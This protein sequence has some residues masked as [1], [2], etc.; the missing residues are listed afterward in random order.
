MK[1]ILSVIIIGLLCFSTFTIF[2]PRAKAIADPSLVGYWKFDE[3]S[4]NT[5]HDSSGNGNDG[6]INQSEWVQGIEGYALRF[7]SGNTYVLTKRFPDGIGDNSEFTISFWVKIDKWPSAQYAYMVMFGQG[8]DDVVDVAF[9]VLLD[10]D[11]GLAPNGTVRPSFWNRHV[12]TT[13]TFATGVWYDWAFVYD[14]TE[15]KMYQNGTFLEDISLGGASPN[16]N[17]SGPVMFSAPATQFFQGILDEVAIYN[18]AR[19]PEEI[20]NDYVKAS[21]AIVVPDDYARIQWAIGNASAGDTIYVKAGTYYEHVVVDKAVS[22]IG[23]DRSSTI[24]DG[25][26]TGN[27]INITANNVNLTGFTIQKSGPSWPSAGIYIEGING[28]NISN[29]IITNNDYGIYLLESSNNT[30]HGNSITAN[31]YDGVWLNGSSNNAIS[32]NNVTKNGAGI[33]LENSSN[34]TISG[35]TIRGN[36]TISASNEYGIGLLDSSSNNTI[37]ENN[38]TANGDFGIWLNAS[39][40]NRIFENDVVENDP[41]DGISLQF[42]SNYNLIYR[43][44]ITSNTGDGISTSYTD[45]SIIFGNVITGNARGIELFYSSHNNTISGNNITEN[46]V[47]GIAVGYSSRN[48]TIYHNNLIDN[49]HQAIIEGESE[50]NVWDDG[51]PSGGNY[52]SDYAGVDRYSGPNQNELGSDGIGDT[53][54]AIDGNNADNYPL[55][56]PWGT[57]PNYDWPM[58]H[59]DLSH[60][61]YSASTAPNTNHIIWNYTTGG[62]IW[63]SPAIAGGKVYVGS[64]DYNVYCLN[65]TTGTKIWNY[66]TGDAIT[67]SPAVV[68]GKV[69]I[70]SHDKKFYALNASNGNLI[71]NVTL[72]SLVDWSSPAVVDGKI[73]I[74]SVFGGVY[75]LNATDG[76]IIWNNG[77]SWYT[78]SPA[79]YDGKVYIGGWDG[80]LYAH[81]ATDGAILWS[82]QTSPK[83]LAHSSPAVA[84][85]GIV[86][87]G[88]GLFDDDGKQVYALNATNGTQ[89]W[90][91]TTGDNVVSSPAVVDGVVYIGSNDMN[92]Y[93]LNASTGVKLWSYATGGWVYSSPAVADGKVYL[94]S[95]N[96]NVYCFRTPQNY[97]LTIT[98]TEA[99][100]TWTVPL[101]INVTIKYVGDFTESFNVTLCWNNTNVIGTKTVTLATG[102]TKT[103]TYTWNIPTIPK[104]WPYPIYT[105]KAYANLTGDNELISSTVTVKWPGDVDGNGKVRLPDLTTLAKAWYGD[106]GGT[107]AERA[108]Y[109]YKCDFDMNGEV[110]LPDLVFLAKNWYKGPLD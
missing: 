107:A 14:K 40:N 103:L 86:Y 25:N 74:A 58:F 2:T 80:K 9:H 87:F 31:N 29:N 55:V 105:F 67:A 35:N 98:A 97:T 36:K 64:N 93:A 11:D 50:T 96:H 43:N 16:F 62:E 4:G 27:V 60:S 83:G 26:G 100:P 19:T 106:L 46:T 21:G 63:S 33:S 57:T 90:S 10:N 32:G 81:N 38:V 42:S 65:A 20:W 78:S 3:G 39:S 53:P 79:V 22:L 45:H 91:Y 68:G 24:I 95:N 73:Y 34:N 30:I 104:A 44:N 61:G 54:Y 88:C 71:W 102:E 72:D 76:S 18:Y 6:T 41:G 82:F 17:T 51:Y 47:D 15:V 110:K 99:Y 84:A 89:I 13:H 37:S 52:W 92:V 85:N 101:K 5:A 48:N 12:Y 94:G 7:S 109:N 56:V 75:A 66:T 23:E 59:H 69:Y 28:N 77:V 70:G 1:K 8:A 108:K 49:S